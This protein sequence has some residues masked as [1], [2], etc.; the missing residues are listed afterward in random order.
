MEIFGWSR[1]SSWSVTLK[2]LENL[3]IF[4]LPHSHKK[5]RPPFQQPPKAAFPVPPMYSQACSRHQKQGRWFFGP[6]VTG[7]SAQA[8]TLSRGSGRQA[9]K[10]L[11][12]NLLH[13]PKKKQMHFTCCPTFLADFENRSVASFA[14]LG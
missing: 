9:L 13:Q 7:N 10:K 12:V 8:T 11:L 6:N 5:A 14:T 1:S 3:R 2:T 4:F